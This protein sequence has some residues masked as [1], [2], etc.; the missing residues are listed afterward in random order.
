MTTIPNSPSPG[1][2]DPIAAPAVPTKPD[3]AVADGTSFQAR[4]EPSPD[5]RSAGIH[6][7]EV[8]QTTQ[9]VASTQLANFDAFKR[10]ETL[11]QEIAAKQAELDRKL[12][13]TPRGSPEYDRLIQSNRNELLGLQAEVQRVQF[14]AE[15]V[16]RLVEHTTSGTRTVL[17]TH[18]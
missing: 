2:S 17:Q 12:A 11:P 3:P 10:M 1:I 14:H 8:A 7:P 4:L 16:S 6:G 15:L 9:R 13:E 5:F 18:A